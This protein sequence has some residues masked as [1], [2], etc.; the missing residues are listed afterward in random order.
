MSVRSVSGSDLLRNICLRGC[1]GRDLSHTALSMKESTHSKLR[2]VKNMWVISTMS[3]NAQSWASTYVTCLFISAYR[4][5]GQC[6]GGGANFNYIYKHIYI[7]Q[8][9]NGPAYYLDG[10]LTNIPKIRDNICDL[11]YRMLFQ[12]YYMY[13]KYMYVSIK[14]LHAVLNGIFCSCVTHEIKTWDMTFQISAYHKLHVDSCF[15]SSW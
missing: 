3:I 5:I 1:S 10:K 9:L 2:F 11:K 14:H 13:N 7:S 4:P 12:M 8:G 15:M 6:R